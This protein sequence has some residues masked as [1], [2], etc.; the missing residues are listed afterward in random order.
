[1]NCRHAALC[2][3]HSKAIPLRIKKRI[4]ADDERF[5]PQSS[6]LFETCVNVADASGMQD[7]NPD[8]KRFLSS[9]QISFYNW[10]I[11]I[12]R[13]QERYDQFSIWHNFVDHFD[14]L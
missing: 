2:R 7:F 6:D 11:L 8:A 9:L 5:C 13:V 10:E 14:A 12:L 4:R 3:K 1:V